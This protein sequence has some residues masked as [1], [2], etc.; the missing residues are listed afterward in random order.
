MSLID[1][2]E[3]EKEE[4]IVI[5]L[6]Q[7]KEINNNNND[8]INNISDPHLRIMINKEMIVQIDRFHRT[9]LE[10]DYLNRKRNEEMIQDGLTMKQERGT[11]EITQAAKIKME[12][13]NISEATTAA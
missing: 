11:I 13:H 6:I 7:E 12:N 3:G 5:E 9:A 2:R 8:K 4:M 1:M 10:Q